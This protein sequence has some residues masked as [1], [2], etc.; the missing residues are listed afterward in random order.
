M[1]KAKKAKVEL[2]KRVEADIEVT[3]KGDWLQIDIDD[4]TRVRIRVPSGSKGSKGSKD[5]K[6]RKDRKDRTNNASSGRKNEGPVA[7]ED[8]E[9]EDHYP[10]EQKKIKREQGG[11]V[12]PW[13]DA[14]PGAQNVVAT[15]A[16]I[17]G[18]WQ[19]GMPIN[20]GQGYYVREVNVLPGQP[21][22][23]VWQ[24]GTPV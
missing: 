19:D 8:F 14:Y 18:V 10:V 13:E 3:A 16:R 22:Q 23:N 9:Y 7:F 2:W 11:H 21:P 20:P 24:P 15:K 5:G 4:E 6:G 1:G 17:A 12:L